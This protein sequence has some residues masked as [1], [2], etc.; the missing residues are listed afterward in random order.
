MTKRRKGVAAQKL[1]V[2]VCSWK[3]AWPCFELN[4]MY[5]TSDVSKK[6]AQPVLLKHRLGKIRWRM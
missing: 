1:L 4:H 3:I 5:K 2:Y 6:K